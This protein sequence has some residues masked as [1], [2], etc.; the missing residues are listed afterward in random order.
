MTA[1]EAM[2]FGTSTQLFCFG[3]NPPIAVIEYDGRTYYHVTEDP[4]QSDAIK[5]DSAQPAI[6]RDQRR[7]AINKARSILKNPEKLHTGQRGEAEVLDALHKAS[8]KLSLSVRKARSN[9]DINTVRNYRRK[10]S[11]VKRLYAALTDRVAQYTIDGDEPHG[12]DFPD[13]VDTPYVLSLKEKRPHELKKLIRE[14]IMNQ[15]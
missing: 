7:V 6:A 5:Q 11:Q 15:F 8:Y 10:R 2:K 4:A 9:G 14:A 1:D 12:S 3:T 13:P